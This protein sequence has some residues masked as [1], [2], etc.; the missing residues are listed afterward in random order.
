MALDPNIILGGKPVQLDN[1]VDLYTKALNMKQLAQKSQVQ[2]QEIAANAAVKNAYNQNTTIG[3][4]GAPVLDQNG[5][6]ADLANKGYGKQALDLKQQYA[7]TN[8]AVQEQKMKTVN[9]QVQLGK[10]LFNQV[11]VGPNVPQETT[12]SDWSN[13]LAQREKLGLA[14]DHFTPQFPGQEGYDALQKQGQTM[15]EKLAQKNKEIDQASAK[16]KNDIEAYSAGMPGSQGAGP[17]N[18][19]D[20]NTDPSTLI[21]YMVQPKQREKVSEE[22]KNAQDIVALKPQ[23]LAAYD[24]GTSKNPVEAA[25]GQKQFEALINTTVKEQ[26]GT[27]RQAA[28]DSIHKNMSPKG[29]TGLPGEADSRRESVIGYLGSKASAPVAKANGIDLSKFHTTNF[30]KTSYVPTPQEAAAELQRRQSKTAGTN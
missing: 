24:R 14:N 18:A 16:R 11:R 12:Q 23:I 9:D 22:I 20:P 30:N 27:A 8:L 7:A 17:K 19:S 28:F 13:M 21:N 25:Q 4:D 3:P 29:I 1:P 15:E 2:D 10:T 6:M 26:E 5:T